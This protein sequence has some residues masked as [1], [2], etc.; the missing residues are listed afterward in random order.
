MLEIE[1]YKPTDDMFLK[2]IEFN[3]EELKTELSNRLVKYTDMVVTEEGIRDA[4][5]DRAKLNK[6][7]K[8]IDEKRKEIKEKVLEPYNAFESKIKDLIA[9]IDK[10][11]LQIDSQIKVFEDK[12][13]EEK[14]K[15]I[16][17]FFNDNIGDLVKLVPFSQCFN[18]RWLNVTF[19]MKDIETEITERIKQVK[20][21]L[22]VIDSLNIDPQI[23]LQVKD[24]FLR[25]FNLSQA[26]AEKSRLEQ[27]KLSMQQ[28][29]TQNKPRE[30]VQEVKVETPIAP[31][32]T[33][34]EPQA[35][36]IVIQDFRVW[37]TKAQLDGLKNYL[38]QNN[39]KYGKV[40][41]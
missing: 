13:K 8:A 9:L 14:R 32:E 39:I 33:K 17:Q 38:L 35:P 11:I 12:V 1:I 6:L 31:V 36:E 19:K 18:D 24:T 34:V 4:K 16:E 2:A 28:Y 23:Q 22:V 15:Q 10:P 26:L 30:A 25:T 20:N 5:D 37:A 7:K 40:G 41:N 29:E 27:Q 21:D 3:Y